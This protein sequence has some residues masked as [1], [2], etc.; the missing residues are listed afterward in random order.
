MKGISFRGPYIARDHAESLLRQPWT[1]DDNVPREAGFGEDGW[2]RE[3][4]IRVSAWYS[5][6]GIFCQSESHCRHAVQW[7]S[8]ILVSE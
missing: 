4:R 5:S 8:I 7:K 6:F 2:R 3:E 1:V